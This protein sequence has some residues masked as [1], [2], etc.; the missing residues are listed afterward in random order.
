MST[1]LEIKEILQHG[2]DTHLSDVEQYISEREWLKSEEQEGLRH[3]EG[4]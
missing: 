2:F 1:Y 4:F 3:D